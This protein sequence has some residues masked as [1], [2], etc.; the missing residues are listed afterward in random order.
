MRGACKLKWGH[1]CILLLSNIIIITT[2]SV[3]V[4]TQLRAYAQYHSYSLALFQIWDEPSRTICFAQTNRC[5]DGHEYHSNSL[6]H[7]KLA[8]E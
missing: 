1:C 7:A 6:L 2:H 3:S 5:Q 8:N 4:I